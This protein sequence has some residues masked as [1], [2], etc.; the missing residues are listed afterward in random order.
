M[1]DSG[2]VMRLVGE[3]KTAKIDII[4]MKRNIFEAYANT[5]VLWRNVTSPRMHADV[6]FAEK[7]DSVQYSK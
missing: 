1:K 6:F 2:K 3:G 7:G 4:R 5:Y